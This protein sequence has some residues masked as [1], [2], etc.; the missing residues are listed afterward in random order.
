MENKINALEEFATK[1]NL[2]LVKKGEVGFGRACVGFL[3][4]NESG[5][6]DINPTTLTDYQ[7]IFGDDDRLYAPDHVNSYHKHDC[8]CV[9]V[10][11]E[12]YEKALS[13]LYDWMRHI[14]N[15][16]EIEIKEYKTGAV[17][18]QAMI[19]GVVGYAI[20]LKGD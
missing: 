13:G 4:E 7:Y 20:T 17:G 2:V 1:H 16:G 11:D 19:S 3:N 12:D 8:L 9:L 10:P 5:Y 6:I 15:Q 18:I 14:E